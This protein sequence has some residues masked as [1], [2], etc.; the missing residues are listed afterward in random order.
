MS[1]D[2]NLETS[3]VVPYKILPVAVEAVKQVALSRLRL[4]NGI[5]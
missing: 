5:K 1:L 4:F 2:P 3:K